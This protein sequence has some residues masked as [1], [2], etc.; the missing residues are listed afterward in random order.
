MDFSCIRISQNGLEF[1]Y[2]FEGTF[3]DVHRISLYFWYISL[4][5]IDRMVLL[6]HNY[7]SHSY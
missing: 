3:I 5:H 7:G 4:G 2:F 1:F 6:S